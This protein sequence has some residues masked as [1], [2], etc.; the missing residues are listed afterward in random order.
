MGALALFARGLLEGALSAAACF[1]V[2]AVSFAAIFFVLICAAPLRLLH[3][4]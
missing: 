2:L 1:A 3:K 4:R